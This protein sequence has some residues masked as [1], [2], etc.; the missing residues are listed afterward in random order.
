MSD[1]RTAESESRPSAGA[2]AHVRSLAGPDAAIR[3]VTRLEGGQ[4]AETWSVDTESPE[5]RV[6]VRRFPP[7]DAAARREREV[8]DALDGLGGLAP[9]VLASDLD[10]RWS[11][12]PTS[13]ISWLDGEPDITPDR[14]EEW[15][16][17]LGK[18]LGVVHAV[19]AERLAALPSVFDRHSDPEAG[20]AGPLLG[21]VRSEWDRIRAEPDVLTHAD[22][23]SGNVVWRNGELTGI[24]DWSGA[25]RGP[26]GYD[27]GWCRLDLV[28]LFDERLADVFVAAYEERA[29][30]TLQD[31]ALWDAWS[32]ARSHDEVETWVP[33][34]APLGRPDLS[35]EELRRRHER[36]T[37]RLMEGL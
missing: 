28:L 27:V 25:S 29:G 16:V 30:V 20:L 3:S 7:G 23:W 22:Y 33:N 32:A 12:S 37:E 31:L 2:L 15:A 21:R 36:W 19:P 26:R 6:V 24:V 18:A 5:L 1:S 34:Y 14:P 17:Q 35:R 10:G 11:E 4:H 9:I 13:L 8:L